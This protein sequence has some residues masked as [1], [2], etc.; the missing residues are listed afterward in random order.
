MLLAVKDQKLIGL[1]ASAQK[2]SIK[3]STLKDRYAGSQD[4]RTAHQKDLSLTVIQEDNL[5][6]YIIERE[7]AFQPL[8]RQEIHDFTQALSAINGDISYI[9][10]N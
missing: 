8:T 9:G 2:H 6:N 5:I 7:R 1:R 3:L 4:I 10:K